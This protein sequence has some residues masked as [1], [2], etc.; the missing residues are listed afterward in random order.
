VLLTLLGRV[1]LITSGFLRRNRRYAIVLVFV[2]A[3]VL[4]PPD[5]LSQ[6]SL[7]I[8]LLGLYEISI[9]SVVLVERRR[10]QAQTEAESSV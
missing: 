6:I 7:A 2:I 1:G 4:T 10:D 3:A 5:A 8:P 9:W